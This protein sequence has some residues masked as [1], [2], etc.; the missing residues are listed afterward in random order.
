MKYL[1]IPYTFCPELSFRIANEVCAKMM[2]SGE[3]VFSPISHSHSIANHLDYSLQVDHEFWMHQDL[4]LLRMCEEVIVIHLW[5]FDPHGR[6]GELDGAR[7]IAQS[8]G[9]QAEL[10]E[11]ERCNIPHRFQ[12]YRLNKVQFDIYLE[13]VKI[14]ENEKG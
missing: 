4:P 14:A 13:S 1:A 11:A 8:R 9:V 12:M 5:Y 6:H 10:R 7:L 2:T 3:V